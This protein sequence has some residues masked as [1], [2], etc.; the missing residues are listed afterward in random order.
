LVMTPPI[1][2]WI[3][4][5]YLH[6]RSGVTQMF[7]HGVEQPLIQK[8]LN[9]LFKGCVSV[10]LILFLIALALVKGKII[11]FLFPFLG[12]GGYPWNHARIGVGLDF[13]TVIA[14]YLQLLSATMFGVVAALATDRRVRRLALIF[15]MLA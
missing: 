13:L 2:Q 7:K 4:R 15:C 9:V 3:N 6:R 8:Q 1:H 12:E 11:C 5:Q 14:F 10:W